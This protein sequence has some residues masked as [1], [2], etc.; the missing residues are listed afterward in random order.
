MRGH[1][2]EGGAKDEKGFWRYSV[3][4]G[5]FLWAPPPAAA[6][7]A[8]EELRKARLKRQ[9]SSHV[10]VCP[11][12]L[13]SLWLKQLHKTADCLFEIPP[14]PSFWPHQMFEP[15]K[16]GIC[17]P[18]FNRKPWTLRSTP[19]MLE[20]GQ[21]MHKVFQ[22][23]PMD[24]GNILCKFL[25]EFRR[26]SPMSEDVVRRMLYFGQGCEVPYCQVGGSGKRKRTRVS[27]KDGGSMGK[28]KS[29]G[30]RF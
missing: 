23:K 13:T 7:V 15:L 27:G 22:E 20:V 18:Y 2:L 21:K 17:F 16:V 28:K 5:T 10:F 25:L 3:R 6:D 9:A 24:A 8:L 4:P 26:F 12:L 29:K 14:S 19:K 11:R 30:G 1:N